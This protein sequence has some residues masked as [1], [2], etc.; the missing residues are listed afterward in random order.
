MKIKKWLPVMVIGLAVM[1]VVIGALNISSASAA[2]GLLDEVAA[3]ETLKGDKAQRVGGLSKTYLAEALG[4]TEEELDAAIATARTSVI[5][6][7]LEQGL[8]TQAQ[9]D[10]LKTSS[11]SRMTRSLSTWIK[12][13]DFD[14][15]TLL[16]E[17]LGISVDE[18]KQAYQ[19]AVFA[20]IDQAV[21]DGKLTEEQALLAKGKYALNKNTAFQDA[22]SSAY[23]AAVQEAVDNGVITQEQAD[24]ILAD[25]SS[26]G[27]GFKD[28]SSGLFGFDRPDRHGSRGLRESETETL[29][30]EP[31]VE[32]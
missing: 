5:D 27:F 24:L 19:E 9:A 6:Q 3:V 25:I 31:A 32:P 1:A 2:S 8:I 13:G 11:S 16:A 23:Q 26:R 12:Q 14:Y 7:A 22:M 21:L 29:E 30:T 15:D 17:A 18:L 4:I 28:G 20:G 10:E